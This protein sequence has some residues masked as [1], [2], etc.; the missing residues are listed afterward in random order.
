MATYLVLSEKLRV[1]FPAPVDSDVPTVGSSVKARVPLGQEGSTPST[2]MIPW[3][4]SSTEERSIRCAEMRVR[5]PQRP[6]TPTGVSVMAT[7]LV[8]SEKLRVR[9]PAPV[10][11]DVP[12]VGSSVKARVPLGQEGSTP[13]TVMIPWALSSTEERSIRCAEMRVRLPQRPM[14]SVVKV[15]YHARL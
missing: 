11:S 8:F 3:A 9:F 10:D 7:Y 15:G 5:L 4:L 12:T 1:R 2:V 6:R 14:A 13:S